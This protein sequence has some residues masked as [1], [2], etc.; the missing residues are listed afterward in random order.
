MEPKVIKHQSTI[1]TETTFS[2]IE[3]HLKTMPTWSQN[4]SAI[5]KQKKNNVGADIVA[6]WKMQ[7][8][9]A[10]IDR[11][12]GP[13]LLCKSNTALVLL[14]ENEDRPFRFQAPADKTKRNK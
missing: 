5:Y 14:Y 12:S 4:G 10:N 7:L 6:E 9:S 1:D 3:N 11:C 13:S 8:R 2:E